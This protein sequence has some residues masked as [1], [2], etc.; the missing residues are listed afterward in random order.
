VGSDC[1]GDSTVDEC[2][3]SPSGWGVASYARDDRQDP[4][5]VPCACLHEV[6]DHEVH[7]LEV[8]CPVSLSRQAFVQDGPDLD[9][10]AFVQDVHQDPL[11]FVQDDHQVPWP[12]GVASLGLR[13]AYQGAF[14]DA[15]LGASSVHMVHA[16]YS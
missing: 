8:A 3:A 16:C 14:L 10:W 12:P 13:I 6:Q 15:C 7:I 5:E 2:A 11:A 9:P 1:I 4:S